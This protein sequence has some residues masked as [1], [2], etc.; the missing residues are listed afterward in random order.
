MK[1]PSQLWV[2]YRDSSLGE[3]LTLEEERRLRL[4]FHAGINAVFHAAE[5]IDKDESQDAI[6]L[7][8]WFHRHNQAVIRSLKLWM[9]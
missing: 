4:A 1:H 7:L 9:K 6:E 5:Q 8:R 3:Q 2:K